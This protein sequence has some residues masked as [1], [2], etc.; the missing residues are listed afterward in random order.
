MLNDSADFQPALKK[1]YQISGKPFWCIN[2]VTIQ[3][4]VFLE[5]EEKME[6]FLL[7]LLPL[8]SHK[9]FIKTSITSLHAR[10]RN[11]K[12]MMMNCLLSFLKA[13]GGFSATRLKEFFGLVN[14]LWPFANP[15]KFIYQ[16]T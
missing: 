7:S 9:L 12:M 1:A 11:E 16:C 15:K 8:N 3:Q 6:F 10:N 13:G 14:G 5:K 4:V 2:I